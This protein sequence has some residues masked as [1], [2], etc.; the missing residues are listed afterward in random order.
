MV[1]PLESVTV[2]ATLNDPARL[3]LPLS[4]PPE[5]PVRPCGKPPNDQLNGGTPPVAASVAE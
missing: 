1:V 2:A 5:E 3:A 4:P